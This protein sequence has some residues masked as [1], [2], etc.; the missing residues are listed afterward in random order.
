MRQEWT[1]KPPGIWGYVGYL[2]HWCLACGVQTKWPLVEEN[3]LLRNRLWATTSFLIP[4][5]PI[6][7]GAIGEECNVYSKHG[8]INLKGPS[9]R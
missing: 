7:R 1:D 2:V 5:V 6:R 4:P 3:S 8:I 9:G